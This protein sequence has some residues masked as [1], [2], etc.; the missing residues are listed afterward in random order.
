MN[1]PPTKKRTLCKHWARKGDCQR[2]DTCEYAHGR[3]QLLNQ[4]TSNKKSQICKFYLQG[5]CKSTNCKFA[6][7]QSDLRKADLVGNTSKPANFKTSM[8]S[9]F[10]NFGFC[11]VGFN[12]NFAHGPE[13]LKQVEKKKHILCKNFEDQGSCKFNDCLF[14]HGKEELQSTPATRQD[15]P[16]YKTKLCSKFKED[17]FCERTDTS[18]AFAHGEDE[19]RKVDVGGLQ[20]MSG[21]KETLC[22]YFTT[23]GSC[24]YGNLC[25]FAHGEHELGMKQMGGGI[26]FG[27]GSMMGSMMNQQMGG[28]NFPDPATNPNI[29]TTICRSWLETKTC[30]YGQYCHHAHGEEDMRPL[31]PPRPGYKDKLCKYFEATGSCKWGEDCEFAHGE[32]ELNRYKARPGMYPGVCRRWLE[33]GCLYGINCSYQ[34]VIPK[35]TPDWKVTMCKVVVQ[36]KGEVSD[37]KFRDR[38]DFAHSAKEL[39]TREENVEYLEMCQRILTK[40]MG[41]TP[42]ASNSGMGGNSAMSGM[43]ANAGM[44]GMGANVGMGGNAGMSGMGPNAGMGGNA[45]MN[46]MGANAV[47]SGMGANANM[48][49]MGGNTAM[50][51]MGANANMS[52]MG[53]NAGMSGM[54]GNVGMIGMGANA[55]MSG[56][57]A[58]AGM[59]GMGN[60]GMR[61]GSIGSNSGMSGMANNGM[62]GMGGSIDA[63]GTGMNGMANS[64]MGGSGMSGMGGQGMNGMNGQRMIGMDNSGMSGMG[65]SSM[66]GAVISSGFGA[67]MNNSG[68]ATN[69]FGNNGN[70]NNS[71][72]VNNAGFG[73]GSLGGSSGFMGGNA[74]TGSSI[75]GAMGAVNGMVGVGTAGM[76]IAGQAN[77]SGGYKKGPESYK[78]SPCEQ[79]ANTGRC[80]NGV[81]CRFAHSAAE[82][83]TP[84]GSSKKGVLCKIW[85]EEG[86]CRESGCKF[87][88]GQKELVKNTQ[89]PAEALKLEACRSMK[90][91]GKCPYGDRCEFSHRIQKRAFETITGDG[92]TMDGKYKVVMCDKGEEQCMMKERCNYAHSYEELDFYRLKQVPNYKRTICRSW[93]ETRS[94]QWE[95]TC[96]FAHGSQ[97]LRTV[98]GGED[99]TGMNM[100]CNNQNKDLSHEPAYPDLKR[101]KY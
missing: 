92:P 91:K 12:C 47:M 58:N 78:T 43:G 34:H 86:N 13:E 1:G 98:E 80:P 9:N 36:E 63:M 2:G 85:L 24:Q 29:K 100:Y 22:K 50:S 65:N 82:L 77:V 54:G 42:G 76:S 27:A 20:K 88:H 60:V 7:G 72:G 52:G 16:L 14:A 26:N 18:C 93:E 37:C 57:G 73:G 84:S 32:K 81:T 83:R 94:C 25:H 68:Y 79:Y 56:M 48:N 35:K 28:M 33:K 89:M 66:G 59:S 11:T 30:Q 19:L 74:M 44:S 31:P 61:G 87:A 95:K 17:G 6:H 75:G 8:C 41:G 97:E 67:N 53:G 10:S 96:M 55:G 15:N 90:E 3:G 70:T 21:Y 69:N 39:R 45:A 64:G 38:C 101:A 40:A 49:G 5:D 99:Q 23:K 46:G 62:G 71:F 4:N 51:G